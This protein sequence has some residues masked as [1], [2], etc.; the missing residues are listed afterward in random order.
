MTL[1]RDGLPHYY[2]APLGE[3]VRGMLP[4][5]AEVKRQFVYR[6][7]EPGRKVLYEGRG[8]G[9]VAAIAAYG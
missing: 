4:L 1:A 8:E 9:V 7:A 2:C 5:S 3:V 6:I